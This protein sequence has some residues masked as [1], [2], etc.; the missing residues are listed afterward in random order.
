MEPHFPRRVRD[1]SA[2]PAVTREPQPAPILKPEDHRPGPLPF[3]PVLGEL[4]LDGWDFSP[5]CRQLWD[6]GCLPNGCF[7]TWQGQEVSTHNN[8]STELGAGG[9][10]PRHLVCAITRVPNTRGRVWHH[11]DRLTTGN[12]LS[13]LQKV[14]F[15]VFMGLWPSGWSQ[16]SGRKAG[17]D[18]LSPGANYIRIQDL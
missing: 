1:V 4:S 18:F 17:G 6:N 11:R 13:R 9:I 7:P 8:K 14:T 3:Y 2:S 5:S 10:W 15:C 16:S 12:R